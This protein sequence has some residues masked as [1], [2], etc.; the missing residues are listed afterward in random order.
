M[1]GLG[2]EFGKISHM[3][4]DPANRR[5]ET[6]NDAQWTIVRHIFQNSRSRT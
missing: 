2:M 3:A 1:P 4:E 6:M 5:P